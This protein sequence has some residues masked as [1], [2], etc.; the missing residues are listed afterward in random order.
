MRRV[1]VRKIMDTTFGDLAAM[2]LV[3][4]G[5]W[6]SAIAG[7]ADALVLVGAALVLAVLGIGQTLRAASVEPEE[8]PRTT[9]GL[10]A[11]AAWIVR[12][13][14]ALGD[15]GIAPVG[16]D[17]FRR[18]AAPGDRG[19]TAWAE[20]RCARKSLVPDS[21]LPDVPRES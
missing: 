13:D 16:P 15:E 1:G 3:V 14:Y 17:G 7:A 11:V 5:I 4:A 8:D 20:M 9:P 21:L 12:A 2:T 10:D 6:R 18:D 19:V